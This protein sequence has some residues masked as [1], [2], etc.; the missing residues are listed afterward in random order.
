MK[1]LSGFV[2]F[3]LLN[4]LSETAESRKL[5]LG[6]CTI[7][8]HTHELRKYYNE[9]RSDVL[10]A[11]NEIGVRLLKRPLMGEAQGEERCCFLRLLL[12]FYIDK[13]FGSH[14]TSQPQ[15]Q[16]ST[17]ALANAFY[18]ARRDLLR[19]CDCHCGEETQRAIDSIYA[20]F[21]KLDVNQAA[22]KAMGELD[23]VLD[24]LDR[25]S[26]ATSTQHD[27]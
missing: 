17:S 24:W 27:A 15:H 18:C 9:I 23:T 12:R 2:L 1:V 20:E 22:L 7:S 26:Q 16:R 6:S 10:A 21:T 14:S 25:L 3:L 8:V 11:D 13:V 19:L 4:C 5:H